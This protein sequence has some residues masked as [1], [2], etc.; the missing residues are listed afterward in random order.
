MFSLKDEYIV[1][2]PLDVVRITIP[3]LI[4]F[5]IMFGIFFFVS[6]KMGINYVQTTSLAF[7]AARIIQAGNCSCSSNLWY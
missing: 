2:L 7:I 5:G 6:K 4:Y 3:I 1:T